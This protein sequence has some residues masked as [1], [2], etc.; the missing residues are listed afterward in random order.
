M[1]IEMGMEMNV[2][3]EMKIEGEKEM[4]IEI[5]NEMKVEMEKLRLIWFCHSKI[6]PYE[7]YL[8]YLII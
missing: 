2:A 4:E 6:S 8:F 5:E 3:T 7:R 1:E